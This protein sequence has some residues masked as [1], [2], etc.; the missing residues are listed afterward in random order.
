M[1]VSRNLSPREALEYI[2]EQ[3]KEKGLVSSKMEA[4]KEQIIES[5]LEN[6]PKNF[7]LNVDEL[8]N[9]NVQKFLMGSIISSS[10]GLKETTKEFADK[11][12]SGKENGFSED[13]DPKLDKK[14]TAGIL[15]LL[16]VQAMFDKTF[17]PPIPTPRPTPADRQA[18]KQDLDTKVGDDENKKKENQ[19]KLNAL[20]KQ[21]DDALRNLFGGE[22]PHQTGKIVFVI[23]GPVFGNLRGFTHQ[24]SPDPNSVEAMVEEITHNTN[25]EDYLGKENI[26]KEDELMSGIVDSVTNTIISPIVNESI[27]M[28]TRAAYTQRFL[29]P[30]SE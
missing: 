27:D 13:P 5:V 7:E 20:E 15:L 23:T 22:D 14:L 1:A 26:A 2:F 12:V 9:E 21:L 25:K 8:K 18:F 19:L 30:G 29:P 3:M 11:L 4:S 16:S 24:S 17:E 6:F 28:S 10:L